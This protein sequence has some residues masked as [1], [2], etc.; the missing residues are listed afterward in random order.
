MTTTEQ[1]R[2]CAEAVDHPSHY[3]GNGIECI[4]AIEA[5]QPIGIPGADFCRGNTVKYLWRLGRKDESLQDARKAQW[6]LSRLI[7]SLEKELAANG[8]QVH[9]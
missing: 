6:Y 5:M 7:Q 1:A 8:N 2:Q 9:Q 4:E 3:A